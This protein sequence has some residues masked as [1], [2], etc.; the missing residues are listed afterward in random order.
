MKSLPYFIYQPEI[1]ILPRQSVP[2]QKPHRHRPISRYHHTSSL[3]PRRL[4][5]VPT[6]LLALNV[7]I[8]VNT[9]MSSEKPAWVKANSS[10]Y[11]LL[12]TSKKVKGVSSWIL[13][14]IWQKNSCATSRA[15]GSMTWYILI[16]RI[17]N[18]P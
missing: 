14:E 12:Q 7:R 11:S 2:K 6:H 3:L 10:S 4:F 13:M 15:N 1:S 16:Q 5:K 17:L 9:C 18:I 8:D